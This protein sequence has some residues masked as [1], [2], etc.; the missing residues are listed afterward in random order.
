MLG[1]YYLQRLGH[2]E[3]STHFHHGITLR[4]QLLGLKSK[5]PQLRLG[6]FITMLGQLVTGC[7]INR[8]K[9]FHS[10]TLELPLTVS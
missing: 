5:T 8:N 7:S 2:I 1:Q 4:S 10:P 6:Y 9:L 3:T